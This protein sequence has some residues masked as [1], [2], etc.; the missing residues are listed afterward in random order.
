MTCICT[1]TPG[2]CLSIQRVA[3]I[4]TARASGP[5]GAWAWW[6]RQQRPGRASSFCWPGTPPLPAAP[7]HLQLQIAR[8]GQEFSWGSVGSDWFHATHLAGQAYLCCRRHGA[9]LPGPSPA[10]R[11]LVPPPPPQ[12]PLAPPAPCGRLL[13]PLPLQD[14]CCP[15]PQHSLG[16]AACL[17]CRALP[18]PLALPL[19]L[20]LLLPLGMCWA[21]CR[22]PALI[23]GATAWCWLPG[24]QCSKGMCNYSQPIRADYFCTP[25][26]PLLQA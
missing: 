20:L 13:Q 12:L 19:L 7:A 25:A 24:L 4:G 18:C 16:P 6:Q 15:L 14:S 3:S 10:C 17:H 1:A 23:P 22:C 2:H 8:A 5:A 26:E 21:L 11:R 9:R